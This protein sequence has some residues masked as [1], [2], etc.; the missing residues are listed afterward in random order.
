MD[1]EKKKH[2]ENNVYEIILSE[3]KILWCLI[4]DLVERNMTVLSKE[5]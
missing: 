4:H 3:C 2:A 1:D 5:E